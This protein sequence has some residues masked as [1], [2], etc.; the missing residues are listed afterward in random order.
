MHE[1]WMKFP[2]LHL[3]ALVVVTNRTQYFCEFLC[4]GSELTGILL[5]TN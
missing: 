2:G 5:N 3:A 1:W 4:N